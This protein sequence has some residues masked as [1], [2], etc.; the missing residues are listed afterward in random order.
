MVTMVTMVIMV[1]MVTMLTM[2]TMLEGGMRVRTPT[3]C[4][5]SCKCGLVLL[6][7]GHDISW[8]V[9]LRMEQTTRTF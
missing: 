1:T 9:C 7:A 6:D 5:V 2:L 3:E 8:Q 4:R